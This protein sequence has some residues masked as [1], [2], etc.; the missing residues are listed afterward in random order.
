MKPLLVLVDLQNDFL[1]TAGLEP[2]AGTTTERASC[3]LKYCRNRGLPVVHIQTTVSREKDHRMQHWKEAKLWRCE[4]GTHG[5]EPPKEL[6]PVGGEI[7]IHKTGFS[8]F[9]SGEFDHAIRT[10]GADTLLI[11]GIHL[12]ACVRQTAIDAYQQGYRVMIAEDT[13]AS[14]DP[15]HAAITRRYLE[16]RCIGFEP[17][18]SIIEQLQ[19]SGECASKTAAP[20]VRDTVARAEAFLKAGFQ[21]TAETRIQLV[22]KLASKLVEHHAE[23]TDRIVNDVGKPIRYAR[24]E[25]HKTSEMLLD[26]VRCFRT[27]PLQ[28]DLQAATLRYRPH[29]V[30]A[31]ITPFNNPLYIALGKVVPAVLYGN[32]AIWKAAPVALKLSKRVVE[33]MRESGWPDGMV[34]LLA[35]GRREAMALMSD[36]CVRAVTLTGSLDAGYTAKEICD[37]RSIPLQAELGGNNAAIVWSDADLNHAAKSIA[38]GAFEMTGQRCTA[39]RRVIVHEDCRQAFMDLLIHHVKPMKW[40]DPKG[41]E[42]QIGPVISERQQQKIKTMIERAEQALGPAIQPLGNMPPAEEG[43]WVPPTIVCCD[44]PNAEIVQEETFGP[45]LVVQTAKSW[46]QAMRLCNGVRQGL[47][48]AIFTNTDSIKTRFLEEAETGILKINQ[49][50]ADAAIGIPFGGWKASGAGVP[51]HGHFDRE[52]FTRPQTIYGSIPKT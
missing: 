4:E 34:T 45:V 26:I 39:N 38:S 7:I 40:G 13:V 32:A 46:D 5:H 29:G 14:N 30:V 2:S 18:H 10:I 52:F 35:G 1:S 37:R 47:S 42:T 22:E 48:A 9:Q 28:D 20:P 41:E 6:A 24:V 25:V 27:L 33:I 51:E 50:T 12:H 23:L 19:L 43:H 36:E 49:S 3:L 15:L 21:T 16:A 8:A 17:V 31:V 44:D 11:A